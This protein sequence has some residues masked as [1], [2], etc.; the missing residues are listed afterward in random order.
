MALSRRSK[1]HGN[2]RGRLAVKLAAGIRDD[3]TIWGDPLKILVAFT[4]VALTACGPPGDQLATPANAAATPP[5][6]DPYI[7]GEV[8]EARPISAVTENCV[9]PSDNTGDGGISPEDPPVCNPDPLTIGSVLMT[10]TGPSMTERQRLYV[11]VLAGS[12][13]MTSDGGSIRQASFGE[14]KVGSTISVWTTGLIRESYPAQVQSA[15]ILIS[16]EE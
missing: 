3:I 8:L 10:G 2:P 1:E 12:P 13:L 7:Q 14:V 4:V 6:R 5:A 9:D 11:G 16:P 15:Y